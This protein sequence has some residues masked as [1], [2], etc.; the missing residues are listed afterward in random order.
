MAFNMGMAINGLKAAM[1]G[2]GAPA[3]DPYASLQ[4]N[5]LQQAGIDAL[6]ARMPGEIEQRRQIQ[7]DAGDPHADF[8]AI[9]DSIMGSSD[10]NPGW[11]GFFGL[12]GGKQVRSG[13]ELTGLENAVRTRSR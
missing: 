8:N 12:L 11:S 4:G 5:D 13:R 6:N 2:G 10:R 3:V 7:T 1:R 9:N